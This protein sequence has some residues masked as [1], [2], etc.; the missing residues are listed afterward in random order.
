MKNLTRRELLKAGST[1]AVTVVLNPLLANADREKE[2]GHVTK[3]EP[4][5]FLPLSLTLG[6]TK[7]VSLPKG[8]LSRQA[9][10][11]PARR[12]CMGTGAFDAFDFGTLNLPHTDAR[13]T[14]ITRSA[15]S[16]SV[17]IRPR[18]SDTRRAVAAS[19]R[20]RVRRGSGMFSAASHPGA[21]CSTEENGKTDKTGLH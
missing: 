4:S 1:A 6:N 2:G 17:H 20:T 8:V 10:R 3:P 5:G 18:I 16:R 14:Y 19:V 12:G 15:K 21:L 7:S 9:R 11:N 13:L